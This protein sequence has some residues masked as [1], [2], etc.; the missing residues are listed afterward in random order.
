[1]LIFSIFSLLF[2]D[3]DDGEK[4]S[5]ICFST[6]AWIRTLRRQSDPSFEIAI[7]G[8]DDI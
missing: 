3:Q 1:M 6:R 7:Y 2:F 5:G 4:D 8:F